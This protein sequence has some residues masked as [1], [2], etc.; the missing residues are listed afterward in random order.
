[1][2][3]RRTALTVKSIGH[4][5][6]FGTLP[7]AGRRRQ[8]EFVVHEDLLEQP[9]DVPVRGEARVVDD[10]VHERHARRRVGEIGDELV[11]DVVGGGVAQL[12]SVAVLQ[13]DVDDGVDLLRPLAVARVVGAAGAEP[14]GRLEDPLRPALRIIFLV[15]VPPV[16]ELGDALV[17]VV[18]AGEGARDL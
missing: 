6:D 11:G 5:T 9:G 18:P 12:R 1:M 13:D 2:C 8:V 17:V 16:V 4:F 3:S 15:V 7:D 14:A 10:V